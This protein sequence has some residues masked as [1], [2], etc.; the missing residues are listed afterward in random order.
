MDMKQAI[1]NIGD[2]NYLGGV[3][4]KAREEKQLSIVYLGGSITQGCNATSEDKRY[5]DISAGWW[6]RNFP[7][8]QV[9]YFNAGIGATTSQYGAAR[10]AG[11]VL[12]KK[13]DLVFVEFS[14]NDDDTMEFME[15]YE[16][17]IRIL[18][19]DSGV[20]AVVLINNLFYDTGANAQG[21][22]N[23]VGFHYK[24]PIVSMRDYM[25]PQILNGD[26][27]LSDYTDDMLH[28][29]DLGHKTIAELVMT[30]L[31]EELRLFDKSQGYQGKPKLPV[32]LTR[33][34]YENASIY[35]NNDPEHIPELEG[36]EV[37]THEGWHF[38][39]PF[40]N[41]WIA[42]KAGSRFSMKVTGNIIGLQ[43]RRSMKKPAPIAHA[44]ID[45]DETNKVILDSNFEEDWGDLCCL[46][47]L[48][49]NAG[50][51]EH[52]VTVVLDQEGQDVDF[53]IISVITAD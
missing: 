30:L 11:H 10:A 37:D 48:T 33:C 14:V 45:G 23:A 21:I 4:Q 47:I 1:V 19:K 43:W 44:F 28:P 22:H 50:P 3:F 49:E 9:T 16:S 40:Q 32:K 41:G 6:K 31:D 53:M 24:L 46:T 15:T 13:P 2:L 38:C 35:R 29:K 36:F 52:T 42:A 34:R 12:D 26:I 51:G 17:L 18:L 27:K 8:T 39:D 5:V 25:Y 7:E 20:K